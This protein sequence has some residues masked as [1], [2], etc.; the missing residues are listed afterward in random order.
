M[1]GLCF[2]CKYLQCSFALSVLGFFLDSLVIKIYSVLNRC[3]CVNTENRVKLKRE[4]Y[5]FKKFS[6]N[7]C[8][9]DLLLMASDGYWV[10]LAEGFCEI[11]HLLVC[12]FF[13]N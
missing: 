1:V 7:K 6:S 11:F 3:S 9:F 12:L 13:E 2:S 4:L 5:L 8:L 10:I